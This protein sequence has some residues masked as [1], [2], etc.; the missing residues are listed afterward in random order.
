MSSNWEFVRLGDHCS[1]IG[2]GATPKGGKNV[3]LES[4]DV[5]L[6]RSQN[7]YNEGFKQGGLAYITN[8]AAEKLEN[9]CVLA[10]DILLNI[11]GDS[12]ARVCLAPNKYLPARVNQHVAII[13]PD[14][15]VFDSRFLR[16]Y[17]SS[18][19]QQNI[20][21]TIASAGATRNALTKGNIEELKVVKPMLSVQKWIADQLESL[22]REGANKQVISSQADSLIK[23]S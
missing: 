2:S 6:I 3:Y 9:V 12:V 7:I 20:L 19:A 22:D 10:G 5:A 17:L 14:A 4:G 1:K 8:S 21:L 15:N 23:I 18:P 11:T 16:Y 13:R